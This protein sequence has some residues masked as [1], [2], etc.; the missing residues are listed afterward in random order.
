MLER[1]GL[2]RMVRVCKSTR[3]III[4]VP[5]IIGVV[6]VGHASLSDGSCR[7]TKNPRTGHVNVLHKSREERKRDLLD[8]SEET[9]T[10]C[11]LCKCG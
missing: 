11:A 4:V 3:K 2:Y 6:F 1:L 5:Q 10:A 7:V 9:G 8:L